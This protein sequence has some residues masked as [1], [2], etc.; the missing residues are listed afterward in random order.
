MDVWFS[1]VVDTPTVALTTFGLVLAA[2]VALLVLFVMLR[3]S[4]GPRDT[5]GL[6]PMQEG[7]LLL[8]GG[9]LL[10]SLLVYGVVLITVD[11]FF[12][13]GTATTFAQAARGYRIVFLLA[14]AVLVLFLYGVHSALSRTGR[15][16]KRP[17]SH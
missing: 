3:R 12:G 10:I 9:L 11:L 15:D 17:D 1:H 16:G 14:V 8:A 6:T 13:A 7:Y 4:S 2:V 5:P